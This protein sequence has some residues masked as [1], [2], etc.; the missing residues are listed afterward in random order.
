MSNPTTTIV[1]TSNLLGTVISD[2]YEVQELLGEGSMGLVFLAE[3]THMKKKVALKVMRQEFLE[4]PEAV[5][6]FQREAQATGHIEHPHVCAA[7]DFGQLDDERF[8]LVMEFLDGRTLGDLLDA[9]ERLAPERA[10]KITR[11]IAQG[12]QRAHELE[13]IHRDLKPENVILVSREG[14]EDFVKIT[15][16]GVAR[17]EV[18]DVQ[19]LTRAGTTM[20]T[21]VYMSPEQAVAKRADGRSDLYTLGVMLFEMLTGQVPFYSESLAV[22]LSMHANEPPPSMHDIAPDAMIPDDLTRIVDRLLHKNPDERFAT[23]AELLEALEAADLSPYVPGLS[24]KSSEAVDAELDESSA[25]HV[26]QQVSGSDVF[27]TDEPEIPATIADAEPP[28]PD[29]GGLVAKFTA[30]PTGAR[31]G[32]VFGA[33]LVVTIPFLAAAIIFLAGDDGPD[34]DQG[35]AGMAFS[36]DEVTPPDLK[37][38]R[39]EFLDD[40]DLEDEVGKLGPAELIAKLEP[41]VAEHGGSAHL[42]YLLGTAHADNG[43]VGEAMSHYDAAVRADPRYASDSRIIS[44]ARRAFAEKDDAKAEPAKAL[45][46]TL[47]SSP[48]A[49]AA[50]GAL[51]EIAIDGVWR[52][53]KRA[54]DLLKSSGRWGAMPEWKQHSVDLGLI[55]KESCQKGLKHVRA[56][57]KSE[58][59]GALPALKKASKRSKEGC[60]LFKKSDCYKCMRGEI[61]TAMRKLSEV[62]KKAPVEEPLDS[63]P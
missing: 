49:E 27:G 39:D 31:Y 61:A 53:R 52:T 34:G 1:D 3:H 35:E 59:P 8:F 43:S 60:G 33:L 11:Q 22:I 40:V 23:A 58:E 54:R 26:D 30:L 41:L 20:G 47:L 45:F 19:N 24:S 28:V 56:L 55:G 42:Q 2:R 38:E 15:D 5:E 10:V 4:N 21:P 63:G 44:D 57:A 6:R 32:I 12:L 29:G 46:T 36:E 62:E 50:E 9:E 48:A 51:L 14:D 25:T 13:V 37:A 17:V 16:F 18:V 7:T